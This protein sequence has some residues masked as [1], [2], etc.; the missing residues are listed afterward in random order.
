MEFNDLVLETYIVVMSEPVTTIKLHTCLHTCM[1]VQGKTTSKGHFTLHIFTRKSNYP[2]H[3]P[4][5]SKFLLGEGQDQLV[6]VGRPREGPRDLGGFGRRG[7]VEVRNGLLGAGTDLALATGHCGRWWYG[8]F[9]WRGQKYAYALCAAGRERHSLALPI[10]PELVIVHKGPVKS[11]RQLLH[12]LVIGWDRRAA[13]ATTRNRGG[14]PSTSHQ[15]ATNRSESRKQLRKRKFFH[16]SA[17][18]EK[19]TVLQPLIEICRRWQGAVI[20]PCRG[21]GAESWRYA[22]AEIMHGIRCFLSL[23]RPLGF[24]RDGR[25]TNHSTLKI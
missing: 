10:Y 17:A 25:T 16:Q 15:A 19:V 6:V 24:A 23:P 1:Y 3:L 18:T 4:G 7:V 13:I 14:E 2:I 21:R 9:Q 8:M 5:R 20:S 12:Q 11:R 22:D